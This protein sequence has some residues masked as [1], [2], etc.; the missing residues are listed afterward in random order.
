MKAEVAGDFAT[1]LS[2]FRRGDYEGVIRWS[3]DYLGASDSGQDAAME[4]RVI[5]LLLSA[6]E[7]WWR[8][9]VVSDRYVPVRQLIE[10]ADEAAA[11]T[12]DPADLAVV[13]Y[14]RGTAQV[15]AESLTQSVATLDAAVELA[16]RAGDRFTELAA[17]ARLGHH[18]VGR[19]LAR[20]LKLL[21]EAHALAKLPGSFRHPE[22]IMLSEGIRTRLVGYIGVAE[23]DK[24][25]F[26]AAE[27]HLRESLDKL[28]AVDARAMMSNYL[29]QLL[30]AE[31]RFEE[32]EEVLRAA[33]ALLGP[34]SRESGHQGYNF[35]QLGK[36]YLEA[37]RPADAEGPLVEGW[38]QVRASGNV[39]LLPLVR[40]FLAELLMDEEFPGRDLSRAAALLDE[41]VAECT[42]T[43]FQRSEIAA[44]ALGAR[45]AA[46]RDDVPTALGLSERAVRRLEVSGTMPALRK[47]EVY[48]ARHDVLVAAGEM[49]EAR[50]WLELARNE[51]DR[52]AS[53]IADLR[54]RKVFFERVR[55][56]R[57]IRRAH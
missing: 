57:A 47:E 5:R 40:N 56:N 10:R 53:S 11:R 15:T 49:S 19:N 2:S 41:T 3:T 13:H 1:A 50:R 39:S 7:M 42:R 18:T 9:A 27:L 37:G 38:R 55:L 14:L 22:D 21:H 23:F 31:G 20:G 12:G 36:L 51:V 45:V 44:L 52:K 16:R 34:D 48:L 35:A 6:S 29:G 25:S 8:D 30:T 43:G 26:G 32:A 54:R 24:G 4:L 28:V 17:L 46:A 33:L